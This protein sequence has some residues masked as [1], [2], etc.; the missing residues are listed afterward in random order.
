MSPITKS[1]FISYLSDELLTKGMLSDVQIQAFGTT[2]KLHRDLISRSPFFK[3][4]INWD[5]EDESQNG[6][7]SLVF[8]VETD[9]PLITKESFGLMLKRL[10]GCEDCSKEKEIPLNMIATAFFFQLDDIKDSIIDNQMVGSTTTK[11]AVATLKMLD[12]REYG[13]FGDKL[14]HKFTNYLY[15]NGWQ[16]GYEAWAGIPANLIFDIINADEFFVPN[17]FERIMFAVKL[18]QH[19]DLSEKNLEL[20]IEKFKNNFNFFTLT[21]DQNMELLKVKL[22]NGKPIF[23]QP[24][25]SKVTLLTAFMQNC[26]LLDRSSPIPANSENLPEGIYFKKYFPLEVTKGSLDLGSNADDISETIVPPLR[27]SIALSNPSKKLSFGQE[28]CRQFSYCGSFWRCSLSNF[29]RKEKSLKFV[30]QRLPVSTG[31]SSQSGQFFS[32][33]IPPVREE[34][35]DCKAPDIPLSN[36]SFEIGPSFLDW[37]DDV[38]IYYKIGFSSDE[39]MD[40][41]YIY[42]EKPRKLKDFSTFSILIDMLSCFGLD[43]DTNWSHEK[44]MKATIMIGVI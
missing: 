4:L 28:Y 36:E 41:R 13:E 29:Q 22:K 39:K 25:L 3:A 38:S 40:S 30:I 1:A 18:L 19:L 16:A 23:D 21:Y 7:K 15:D 5:T 10:Y 37:R 8:N 11:L 9:D 2:Y 35:L 12:S 14:S 34:L 33:K 17:E 42:S 27:F 31:Q 43:C 32:S 44:A 6:K 24:A 26:T 20:V